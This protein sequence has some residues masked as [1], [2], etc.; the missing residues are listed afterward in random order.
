MGSGHV[1]GVLVHS[2]CWSRCVG[3]LGK[4]GF[5]PRV[6]PQLPARNCLQAHRDNSSWILGMVTSHDTAFLMTQPSPVVLS[7]LQLR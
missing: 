4:P 7:I 6:P 3:P 2:V 5:R 1:T